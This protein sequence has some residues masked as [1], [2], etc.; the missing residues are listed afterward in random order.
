M[1][2]QVLFI[3]VAGLLSF[4]ALATPSIAQEIEPGDGCTMAEQG[5]F[6]YTGGPANA[7]EGH[8]V[9]CDGTE[10]VSVFSFGPTGVLRPRLVDLSNCADGDTITYHAATGGMACTAAQCAFEDLVWTTHAPPE[11]ADWRSVIYGNGMFVST[12][13]NAT[14]PI[15]T[16]TDGMNWVS[17]NSSSGQGGSL[18]YG[19]GVYIDIDPFSGK[20]GLLR[21]TDGITWTRHNNVMPMEADWMSVAYG[22]QGFVALMGGPIGRVAISP[23][24]ISWSLVNV[25]P[26]VPGGEWVKIVYEGGRYVA[27]RG[28]GWDNNGPAVMSSP[29]GVNWTGHPDTNG[30]NT[31]WMAYGGGRYLTTS[32]ACSNPMIST[33]GSDWTLGGY[34]GVNPDFNNIVYA[35]GTGFV[36]IGS[37]NIYHSVDGLAWTSIQAPA[38]WRAVWGGGTF[39]GISF[40]YGNGVFVG[41][42][43][44]ITLRGACPG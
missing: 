19:N 20:D 41:V 13:W 35:N 16:S 33:N 37:G 9:S 7:G 14:Q 18:A 34:T 8:L 30:C 36:G 23:D 38:A 6:K 44:G 2:R 10:W 26:S 3:A 4:A 29:D 5:Q 21:S 31:T 17:Q 25:E 11:A 1:K 24:G 22:A 32:W 12:A 27:V 15:M 42:S 40:T 28:W 39:D 43:D